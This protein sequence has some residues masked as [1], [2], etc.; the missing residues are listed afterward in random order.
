VGIEKLLSD[1][2]ST[3]SLIPENNNRHERRG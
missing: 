1:Y 3:I 2:D